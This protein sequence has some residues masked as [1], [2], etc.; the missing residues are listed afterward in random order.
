[1]FAH[2]F[3]QRCAPGLPTGQ[4]GAVTLDAVG[5]FDRA[6]VASVSRHRTTK[7]WLAHRAALSAASASQLTPL[8]RTL[9]DHL[10][11]T[12]EALAEASITPQH[13]AAIAVVVR[14]VGP[15]HAVTAEPILL[16]LARRADPAAVRQ[17]P[18][19]IVARVDPAGA[20]RALYDAS[21][22]RGVSLSVA[23]NHG[24]LDGVF[25]VESTELL[26][27][28]LM[29]LMAP[30]GTDD[31][32]S[33]RQRRADALLDIVTKHLSSAPMPQVGGHRPHLSIV[34]QA[35]QLPPATDGVLDTIE[36]PVSDAGRPR[37][38]R[39]VVSL[40]WTGVAV[41]AIVVRRWSCDASLSP[42]LARLLRR[43]RHVTARLAANGME[44]GRDPQAWLPLRVGRTQRTATPAQRRALAVRDGGCIHP[45]CGRT[46]AFCDAHHVVHGAD[47]GP[48]DL[49]NLVLLCRHHHRTLHE[50]LW[51]IHPDPGSPG[52]F[53]TTD[54]NGMRP[55]QTS[56]DR[57][58]PLTT[59]PRPLTPAPVP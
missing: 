19:E 56:G 3:D 51:A 34:V 59:S 54:T 1:M 52:V 5:A 8:A 30:T 22:T 41:P 14:T 26:Q 12:R 6:E 53:W 49:D 9:R 36:R 55:A 20:A 37:G 35:D 39:G 58:P 57:S 45:G 7:R 40:P 2:V 27:S 23:G 50:G 24:C 32:R 11:A 33:A 47:G 44:P 13:A 15:E 28:A 43:P 21:N 42:V 48:S 16:G 10:P 38:W 29:P 25:D 46:P 4:G 18:A 31:T 17:A